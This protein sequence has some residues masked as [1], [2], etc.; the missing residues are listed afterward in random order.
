MAKKRKG[1]GKGPPSKPAD[2]AVPEAAPDIPKTRPHVAATF[3]G[4]DPASAPSAR[5]SAAEI[6]LNAQ[7]HYPDDDDF[8]R[9]VRQADNILGMIE[10]GFLFVLLM[11][12]VLT[13]SAAALSDKLL[14]DP[15][16]RWWFVVVRG[17]TFTIAMIGAVFATHQQRHL[18]MDLISRSLSPRGRLFL[19]AALKVFVIGIMY[20]LFTS[21]LH[22]RENIGDSSES[23][24]SDKTV[25]TTLPLGAALI[26]L[27]SL[28]HLLIDINYIARKKLPPERMRSGH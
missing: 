8:A 4:T 27:H 16:G 9:G 13:A 15:L 10:Q 25:V 11:A 20:V 3:G 1:S 2:D 12:I 22:V 19:A 24:I 17:G 7:L 23:F 14:H 6:D 18:A 26:A 5:Q 28:L 21:G